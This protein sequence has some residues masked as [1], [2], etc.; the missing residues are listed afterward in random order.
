MTQTTTDPNKPPNNS[1]NPAVNP[2]IYLDPPLLINLT[3]TNHRSN[4]FIRRRRK[5]R[6]SYSI[7]AHPLAL[8]THP[9]H[10]GSVD[11]I[12]HGNVLLH[13]VRQAGF[14]GRRHGGA[15]FGNAVFEAV[16]VDSLQVKC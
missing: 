6:Q 12:P 11:N 7:L 2:T 5:L 8:R 1:I 4:L 14:L 3:E 10:I 13:A 9:A 15:R 16:F